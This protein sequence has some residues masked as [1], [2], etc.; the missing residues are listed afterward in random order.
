MVLGRRRLQ[1][2]GSQVLD[3]LMCI[4]PMDI[5]AL[6]LSFQRSWMRRCPPRKNSSGRWRRQ[7]ASVHRPR[8]CL[9]QACMATSWARDSCSTRGILCM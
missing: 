2:L 8:R 9:L 6:T 3:W 4:L 1:N 5:A 7:Q